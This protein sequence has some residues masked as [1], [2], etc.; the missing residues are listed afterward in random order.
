ME[1]GSKVTIKSIGVDL[2]EIAFRLG[3]ITVNEFRQCVGFD[4]VTG[5]DVVFD[6]TTFQEYWTR[7]DVS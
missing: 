2:T 5:G 7:K 3:A 6:M 1:A 4:P